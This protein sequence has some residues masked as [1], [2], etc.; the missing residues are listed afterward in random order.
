MERG[1]ISFRA[2]V[3]GGSLFFM[4]IL[5]PTR[6]QYK[7]K[8]TDDATCVFCLRDV[9]LECANLQGRYWRVVANR[10]PYMDGNVLVVPIRHVEKLEDLSRDEW[11]D[12]GEVVTRTRK[13]LGEA[14]ETDSFNIGM[15]LGPESGASIPHVH[16]QIVP[17]KFKNVTVLN[18]FADLHIVAVTPEETKRRLDE[19]SLS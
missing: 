15:N 10:Y 16:W 6:A 8:F 18:A 14:F 9:S 4:R 7:R 5:D 19:V 2:A 11:L 17:R 13:A 12:F 1:N 3:R